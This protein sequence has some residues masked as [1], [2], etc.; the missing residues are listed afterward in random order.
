MPVPSRATRR[1]PSSPLA[2]PAALPGARRRDNQADGPPWR[3]CGSCRHASLA[4]RSATTCK[5]TGLPLALQS[6]HRRRRPPH[7]PERM[8]RGSAPT[9]NA[10]LCSL[11]MM[12]KL[13]TQKTSF[14]SAA[15][16]T[17]LRTAHPSCAETA[18]RLP[19]LKSR[20][21][22]ELRAPCWPRK[23]RPLQST[24]RCSSTSESRSAPS[25]WLRSRQKSCPAVSERP[26]VP[27]VR[28][29]GSEW[30]GA[31]HAR[32]RIGRNASRR[33]RASSSGS[34]TA[35]KWP[36]VGCSAQEVML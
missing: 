26:R 12:R 5:R 1:T 24:C 14:H 32:C 16:I 18:T 25:C 31:F 10:G 15:V 29:C 34:A 28:G 23:G 2:R 27:D 22:P 13:A 19:G 8:R 21:A 36:P 20:P 35:G 9:S 7:L 30:C 4:A 11:R 17:A 33:L 6:S 3:G